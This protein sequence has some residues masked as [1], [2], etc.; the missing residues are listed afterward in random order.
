[1]LTQAAMLENES[2]IQRLYIKLICKSLAIKREI[3]KLDKTQQH[4]IDRM[5]TG[6]SLSRVA[7]RQ[8]NLLA[9]RLSVSKL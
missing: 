2:N 5:A 7:E 6:V 8:K 3:Y 4:T 1:M 9:A